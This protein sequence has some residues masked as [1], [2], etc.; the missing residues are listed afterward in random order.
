MIAIKLW[1]HG[2]GSTIPSE[3]YIKSK[4]SMLFLL[5]EGLHY[6]CLLNLNIS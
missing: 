1:G 3:N 6:T 5:L 2:M 4:T